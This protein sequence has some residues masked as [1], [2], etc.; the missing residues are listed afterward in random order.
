MVNMLTFRGTGQY[1][2][3]DYDPLTIRQY[4]LHFVLLLF[5]TTRDM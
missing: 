3:W 4:R 5:S 2:F 1:Y